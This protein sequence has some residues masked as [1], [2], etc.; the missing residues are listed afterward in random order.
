M[1]KNSLKGA[2]C[3]AWIIPEERSRNIDTPLD[4]LIVQQ[5][6]LNEMKAESCVPASGE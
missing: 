2:D 1:E 4:L 6:L 3:R 5:I